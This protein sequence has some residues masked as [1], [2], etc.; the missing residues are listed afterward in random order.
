MD[1]NIIYT[2]PLEVLVLDGYELQWVEDVLARVRELS[3][4]NKVFPDSVLMMVTGFMI[5]V[6]RR[7][8]G[9]N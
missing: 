1:S 5:I 2:W 3:K 4:P 9:R 7:E 8:M 6:A